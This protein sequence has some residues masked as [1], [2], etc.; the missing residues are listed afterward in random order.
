MAFPEL[1]FENTEKAFKAKGVGEL[2]QSLWLFKLMS[3]PFLVKLFSKLTIFAIRIGLPVS[4][5]IKAT[6]FKQFCGGESIEESKN[7]VE[8]L[9]RSHIGSILDYSIEGKEN[10]EDFCKTKDEILKIIR[11][12]KDNPAIPYTSLKLTGIARFGLLEKLNFKRQL[13]K[14]EEKEFQ[15]IRGRLT[16]ISYYAS[17][18]H[19][20]VYF[21]AEESW[22]Q[23]AVD[24]L[25]EEMMEL[26]NKK[27]AIVLT[28]LQM[29]RWDRIE[30]LE[31]LIQKARAKNFFIGI[32]LVRGAY[33]EKEN[34]RAQQLG[35]K[36]PIQSSKE[37]TDQ[38]FNLAVDICLK[39]IDVVTLCAGT[40]NETSTMYLINKMKELD[41]PNDHPHVYFSQ[42][43]GMSDHITYNLADAGY[44][45]TKYLPYG[46]VKSVIP[47]LIR[48]AEE[49]TA[50]A[51]QLG[52]ELKLIIEEKR[53]RQYSRMLTA[54]A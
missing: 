10:E 39:N 54:R 1:S 25:A 32:K 38:D 53:R 46:P 35:Y 7:V 31:N 49:N 8:K 33:M 24:T 47:Y 9:N 41:I 16:E 45:V 48:R 15:K 28:T 51:G 40:H 21:D 18:F 34:L 44:N 2:R 52:R 36:S 4:L 5:P 13:T 17:L 22:I 50:I 6:I 29:Y 14:K 42:L 26:N 19:V 30:Y 27:T 12:A 23:E 20:P 3:N 11:V 37:N 43:Y